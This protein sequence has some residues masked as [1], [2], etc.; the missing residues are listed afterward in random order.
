MILQYFIV[1]FFQKGRDID[2]KNYNKKYQMKMTLSLDVKMWAKNNK[3]GKGS[4]FSFNLPLL[5]KKYTLKKC[6]ISSSIV[7]HNQ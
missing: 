5:I 7:I 6:S 2:N 3:D 1:T 4:T